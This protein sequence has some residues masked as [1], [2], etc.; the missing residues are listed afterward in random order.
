[1]R[2]VLPDERVEQT[3][4]SQQVEEIQQARRKFSTNRIRDRIT[5]IGGLWHQR[6][7]EFPDVIRPVVMN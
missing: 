3:E 5:P 4:Y 7:D 2:T 1:M 6:P